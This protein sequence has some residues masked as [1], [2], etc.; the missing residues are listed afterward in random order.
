MYLDPDSRPS[1]RE[2]AMDRY[3]E[4][5]DRKQMTAWD[6]WEQQDREIPVN[7]DFSGDPPVPADIDEHPADEWD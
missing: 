3:E 4:Y 5:K 1:A 7:F 6:Q 2:L